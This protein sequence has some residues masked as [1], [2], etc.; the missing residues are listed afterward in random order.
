MLLLPVWSVYLVVYQL[1]SG[2]QPIHVRSALTLIGASL[3]FIG[4]YFI[5]Q[6]YDFETDRINMKLGFLQRRLIRRSEMTAAYIS[7][8]LVASVLGFIVQYKIGI[9]FIL[10]L[11]LGFFYSAPPLRFKDRPVGGLLTNA[12][13]YSLLLPLTIPGFM[14]NFDLRRLLI[15][16]YFFSAISATYLLTVIPDCEGDRKVGKITLAALLPDR[17]II[18]IGTILLCSAL[19]VSYIIDHNYLQIITVISIALF[20]VALIFPRTGVVPVACKLPILLMSLLA[21]YYYPVY[22]IFIIVLLFLTRL[23]YS[24]RFGIIYPRLN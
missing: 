11:I 13:A 10:M 1:H 4:A 6:L 22:L 9:L 18:L 24:R 3:L 5:N 7:V 14:D 20:L 12:V 21:G 15:A 19:Y 16:A 17:P 8:S 23:Y 2:H